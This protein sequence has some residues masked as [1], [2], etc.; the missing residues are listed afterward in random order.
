MFSSSLGIFFLI[1]IIG[2]HTKGDEPYDPWG[3]MIALNLEDEI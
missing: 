2:L 1:Y 3:E